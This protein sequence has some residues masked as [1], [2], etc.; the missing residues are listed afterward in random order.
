MRLLLVED[1]HRIAGF[2]IKGLTAG[3]YTVE[4]VDT[5][6]EAIRRAGE[7]P[8]GYGGVL[9]DLGLPDMDGLEVLRTLRGWGRELPV[10]IYTARTAERAEGLALGASDFLTKPLPFRQ[11]LASVREHAGPA[12]DPP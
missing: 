6:A 11:V 4:H 2:L 10:I 1:E 5:G 12:A 7:H 8:D 3:G 9:L